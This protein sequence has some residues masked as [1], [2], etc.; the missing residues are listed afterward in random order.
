MPPQ[1]LPRTNASPGL[2]AACSYRSAR[3]TATLLRGCGCAVVSLDLRALLLDLALQVT[4][5]FGLQLD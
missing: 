1:I 4:Q 2:L 5:L 3:I